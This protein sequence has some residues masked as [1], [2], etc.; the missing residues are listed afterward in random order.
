[1][2]YYKIDRNNPDPVI[3]KR[4]V[5][6]LE[7]GGLIVYPTDTLYGLGVDAYNREAVNKL[8]LVKQRDMRKPVSI[9]LNSIQQI[10]EIFGFSPSSIKKDLEKILPGRVTCI[11][12]NNLQ[13]KVPIFESVE[14]PGTFLDK[15]GIR[16][17]S[18]KVSSALVNLFDSPISS[19]SAN[20]SG[21]SNSFSIQNVIAQFGGELDLILDAGPIPESKGSSVIDMTKLPYIIKRQGDVSEFDLMEL[22]GEEK[23]ISGRNKFVITFV[24]SG[25]I[26]RS[27]IAE[28]ILKKMVSKTKYKY[29][30]KVQSAGTLRLQKSQAHDF[31]INVCHDMDIDLTKHLSNPINDKI[32]HESEIVFCLAQNH[33][34]YLVKKFPQHKKKFFLLKQ[35]N[36]SQ[37]LSIPSIADPIG[38]DLKFFKGTYKEIYQEIKRILPAVLTQARK[39]SQLHELK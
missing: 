28:A 23:I 24:C 1:M 5:D 39:F 35:W 2:Q 18:D 19:T 14:K 31:A 7:K 20:I 37:I 34:E 17:P 36:K 13:K 26:C 38:H 27:P 8:F 4:A 12:K 15:V 10:K 11:I 33:Y 6:C 3:I 22:L 29:Q 16:I 21:M 25:N 30:I 9:L 32:V